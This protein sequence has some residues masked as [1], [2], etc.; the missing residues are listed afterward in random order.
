MY[1]Y[2]KVVLHLLQIIRRFSFLDTSLLLCILTCIAKRHRHG[3]QESPTCVLC[4]VGTEEIGHLLL[5]CPYSVE[6]W[7]L[8]PQT[9][10]A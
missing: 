9:P 2:I 4:G 7:S 8:A 1:K 6:V 3:L 10:W 5:A